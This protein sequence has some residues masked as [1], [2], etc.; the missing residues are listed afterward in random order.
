VKGISL[1]AKVIVGG[2]LRQ[3]KSQMVTLVKQAV[4][5]NRVLGEQARGYPPLTATCLFSSIPAFRWSWYAWTSLIRILCPENPAVP[6]RME[7]PW[8]ATVGIDGLP[9]KF[10]LKSTSSSLAGGS[11]SPCHC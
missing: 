6:H 11:S 3:H 5:A 7:I 10:Y 9:Q 2:W 1:A 4:G 8:L